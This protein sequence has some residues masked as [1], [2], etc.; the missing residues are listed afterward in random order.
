MTGW[1]YG[2][3]SLQLN[4]GAPTTTTQV[5]PNDVTSRRWQ[6]TKD[7]KKCSFMDVN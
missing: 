4:I 5:A 7:K 1:V 2:Q 6:Y 3:V